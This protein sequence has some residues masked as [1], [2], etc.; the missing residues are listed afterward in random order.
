MTF[1]ILRKL[2]KN[3]VLMKILSILTI[4]VGGWIIY[5]KARTWL[6]SFSWY[7]QYWWLL[8]IGLLYLGLVFMDL[9][10]NGH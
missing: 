5:D 6:M 8:A 9:D 7:E 10:K 2:K 3:D 1:K 4:S